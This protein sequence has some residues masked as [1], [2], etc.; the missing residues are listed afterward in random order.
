MVKS[1]FQ[2]RNL[3]I[4]DKILAFDFALLFLVLL[5][6]II[7]LFAMYSTDGGEFA[8]N[9]NSHIVRF[10]V[11]IIMINSVSFFKTKLA[12]A[13]Y[14]FTVGGTLSVEYQLIMVALI[15]RI[16]IQWCHNVSSAWV[17]LMPQAGCFPSCLLAMRHATRCDIARHAAGSC[18]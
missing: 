13:F 15:R 12:G 8:Y 2:K 10:I 9:K 5:L 16:R 11:F 7:S 1:Y 14:I 6:G 3:S 18:W 4:G 17:W